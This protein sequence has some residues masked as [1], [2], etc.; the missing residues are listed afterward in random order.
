MGSFSAFG[1]GLLFFPT[2]IQAED[3]ERKEKY[4]YDDKTMFFS[5]SRIRAN[6]YQENEKQRDAGEIYS[7]TVA[8]TASTERFDQ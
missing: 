1:R 8:L 7:M 5:N 2:V 4:E 3:I 6:D